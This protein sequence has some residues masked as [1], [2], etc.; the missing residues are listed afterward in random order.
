MIWLGLK[1]QRAFS[2]FNRHT[3]H[4]MVLGTTI[5]IKPKPL[6]K[7]TALLIWNIALTKLCFERLTEG[8]GNSQHDNLHFH[9]LAQ[10]G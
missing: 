2:F 6:M 3:R 4:R 5:Q 1:T 9:L 7:I 10:F 8:C